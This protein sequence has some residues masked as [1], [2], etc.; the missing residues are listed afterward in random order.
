MRGER[1]EEA[2]TGADG[3]LDQDPNRPRPKYP[4]KAR[5]TMTMITTVR[6]SIGPH[7]F[8]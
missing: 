2:R 4:S 6:V 1:R 3:G 7:T 8:A 5:T